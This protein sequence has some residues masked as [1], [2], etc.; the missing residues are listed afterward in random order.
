MFKHQGHCAAGWNS[1][2]TNK[3]NLEKCFM[4]CE[5]R[6]NIGYFAYNSNDGNCACYFTA[7]GCPDDDLHNDYNAYRINLSNS[8]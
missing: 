6:T 1:P 3:E 7:N 8:I 4:E 2:N 5:G